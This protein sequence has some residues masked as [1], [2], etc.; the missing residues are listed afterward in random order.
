M[1]S[2]LASR[3]DWGPV[4]LGLLLRLAFVGSAIQRTVRRKAGGVAWWRGDRLS[5]RDRCFREAEFR[6]LVRAPDDL[7]SRRCAP[8]TSDYGKGGNGRT[9]VRLD[10]TAVRQ[11]RLV[12]QARRHDFAHWNLRSDRSITRAVR[13][14]R[15]VLLFYG[16]RALRRGS[17]HGWGPRTR[18][19]GG[20]GLA[21]FVAPTDHGL[22]VEHAAQ[23]YGASGR[24]V[25]HPR[26]YER[27]PRDISACRATRGH[28]TGSWEHPFNMP[29]LLLPPLVFCKWAGPYL[30][31][32]VSCVS[33]WPSS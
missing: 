8:Q 23:L 3:H 13:H 15:L 10:S 27:R 19:Q 31:L 12:G 14:V 1:K 33:R 17:D 30:F 18:P 4:A 24:G 29:L 22:G 6:R 2:A 16:N 21:D 9:R 11:H 20:A 32:F 28:I 7:P 26:V 5:I 25:G